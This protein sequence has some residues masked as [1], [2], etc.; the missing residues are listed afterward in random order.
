[1]L[2]RSASSA[3]LVLASLASRA[4]ALANPDTTNSDA[5][6]VGLQAMHILRGEL[7]PLLLGS[8]Y[9]TSVDAFVAAGFF[10]VLGPTPFALMLSALALHIALTLMVF[11]VLARA[12][13]TPRA[14][15][16][17]ILLLCTGAAIHSY[18]LYPPRQAA[19]T[20][21]IGAVCS[22]LS[23]RS[24]RAIAAGGALATLSLF[25]DPYAL[26]VL[27]AAAVSG[28]GAIFRDKGER[29]VRARRAGALAIG[30]LI[31]AIPLLLLA[32]HPAWKSGETGLSLG[33]LGKNF[34]LLL[35]PCGP[36]AFGF[37]VYR[38]TLIANYAPWHPALAV[39]LVQHLGAALLVLA[40]F[41]AP[42]AAFS[43]RSAHA[44]RPLALAGGV[45]AWST[46]AGFLLSVMV[47]DH[48]SM[49]YLAAAILGAP[50]ALA[51]LASMLTVR[52]AFALVAPMAA[53]GLIGGWASFGPVVNGLRIAHL[54][55]YED[56]QALLA[57]LDA[58]GLHEA[59]ADYWVSYRLAFLSRERLVVI[60]SHAAQDRV[61]AYVPRVEAAQRYAYIVDPYRSEE[62]REA[63]ERRLREAGI[64]ER[65][66]TVGKMTVFVVR[67]P[68]R[69]A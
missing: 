21:A 42:F 66:L 31:G 27:P 38:P 39:R 1:V 57:A 45:L 32:R 41:V 2:S 11:F 69:R 16:L 25:A 55:G 53:S 68:A 28:L 7:S 51:P 36:W 6:L 59:V 67:G 34:G 43:R 3:L 37:V 10:A 61:A 5:A 20:L 63:V 23:A 12:L 13:D 50:F 35:S 30:A 18:A 47:M 33:V 62:P 44:T 14:F 49:R 58:D 24:L 4:P 48:F 56:E 40:C 29:S 17:S 54:P 22:F 64:L 9:Q 52:R 46:L 26:L 8:H 19:L 65:T 60:P 15:L